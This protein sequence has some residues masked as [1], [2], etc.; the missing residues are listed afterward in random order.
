MKH[1]LKEAT[2]LNSQ[3]KK[4]EERA[5]QLKQ[6]MTLKRALMGSKRKESTTSTNTQEVS[7]RITTSR[8]EHTQRKNSRTSSHEDKVEMQNIMSEYK[9][10]NYVHRKT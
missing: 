4:S 3:L 7:Q 5:A 6:D 2:D 1:L 10:G 8:K 9:V